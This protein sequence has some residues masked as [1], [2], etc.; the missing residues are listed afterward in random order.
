MPPDAKIPSN[1]E[2]DQA[3]KEFELKS[4]AEEIKKSPEVLKNSEM[5]KMVRLVIKWS[6][7]SINEKQANYVLF[8]FVVIAI[9]ISLFLF[10]GGGN[11]PPQ[12]SA[13]VLERIKQMPLNR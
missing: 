8:G 11:K 6:G 4:Q 3:L 12:P 5:P 13:A 2:I 10:F 1:S 9:G 7:G